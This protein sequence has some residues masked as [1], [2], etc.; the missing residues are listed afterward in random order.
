MGVM[1]LNVGEL[2]EFPSFHLYCLLGNRL[3]LFGVRSQTMGSS[4]LECRG[5]PN[6]PFLGVKMGV[7]REFSQPI[8]CK[9]ARHVTASNT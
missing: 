7:I 5:L 9:R 6:E 3:G 8:G 4:S 1:F 2:N